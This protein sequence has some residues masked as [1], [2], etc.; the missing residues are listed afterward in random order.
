V[1]ARPSR[2]R[3]VLVSVAVVVGLVVVVGA[4]T[5]VFALKSYRA[6]SESMLPTI[7]V[8]DRFVVNQ[9][10]SPSVGDVVVFHP[11]EGALG[12]GTA[13]GEEVAESELCPK[14]AGGKSDV[15]YVKRAV[16]GPGDR[17]RIQDGQVVLDGRP[18]DEPYAAPC[19]G[20]AAT[21][22]DFSGEITVPDGHWYMLGDNRGASDDSRFWGPVPD[23]WVVGTVLGK[24]WPPSEIGGL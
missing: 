16:A 10:G 24:Y 13:C 23:E 5:V 2:R 20:G 22:C 3:R 21:G 4:L 12:E 7:E 1:A 17:L 14:P 19:A 8:G 9:L 11:P 6:P 15:S 18:V